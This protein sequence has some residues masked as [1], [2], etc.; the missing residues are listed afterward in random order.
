MS[1]TVFVLS[2]ILMDVEVI[3]R[4]VLG[5]ERLHGFTN[6]IGGATLVLLPAVYVGRPICQAVLGWWNRNLSPA[7][8]GWLSTRTSI[9]W[10]AAWAGGI[11]GV[12]SHWLLD[13][14]MHADARALWPISSRNPFVGWLSIGGVNTV[15]TWSLAMGCVGLFALAML[16]RFRK[17]EQRGA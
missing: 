10:K 2:Q 11:L 8:R 7:Q 14:I 9:S 13:A 5:A 6:T 4:L 16:R 3:A 17:S 12:Y 1:F 15:C